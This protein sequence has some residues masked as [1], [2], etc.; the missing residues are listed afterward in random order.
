MITLIGKAKKEI[1]LSHDRIK[2]FIENRIKKSNR[3]GRIEFRVYRY[4]VPMNLT[5]IDERTKYSKMIVEYCLPFSDE[6]IRFPISTSE[7]KKVFQHFL[8]FI[9]HLWVLSHLSIKDF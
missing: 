9:E 5:V 4:L 8:D 6:R 1:N 2:M 3:N 7:S